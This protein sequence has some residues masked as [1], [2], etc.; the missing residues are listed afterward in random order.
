[1]AIPVLAF[2]F[3]CHAFS[4]SSLPI[5]VLNTLLVQLMLC[6]AN[7]VCGAWLGLAWTGMPAFKVL[8]RVI[9]IAVLG[10]LG[11]ML[12]SHEAVSKNEAIHTA[13]LTIQT[14]GLIPGC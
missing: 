14:L 13:T 3:Y 6:A 7:V 12:I 11:V 1:V 2:I 10:T 4:A 9:Y 5:W 8:L